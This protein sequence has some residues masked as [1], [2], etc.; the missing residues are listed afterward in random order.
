MGQR[1]VVTVND[2]G[3]DICKMYFHW[4]AYSM[5][6]LYVTRVILD[7]I[8]EENNIMDL[9]LRLIRFCESYGGGIYEGKDSDEWKYIQK[10]YPNIAFKEEGI[11][12]NYGLIAISEK[13][14][15]DMQGWSEGDMYIDIGDDKVRNWINCY[16]D[17]VESYNEDRHSWDDDW[18][19]ISLEDVP[20]INYDL[21]EFGFEDIDN[22]IK[23]LESTNSDIVRHGNDIYELIV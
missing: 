3:K 21:S 11:N 9:R 14:M 23:A 5:S 10:E 13:G 6:A 16:Y 4:S 17:S 12:R 19:D 20:E 15:N 18:E 8:L 1:L 22:V 7:A 2:N